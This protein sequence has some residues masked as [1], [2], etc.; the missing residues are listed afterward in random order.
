MFRTGV[1]GLPESVSTPALWRDQ[2][3]EDSSDPP[4][5]ALVEVLSGDR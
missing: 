2:H 5:G 3:D 4:V 1:Q